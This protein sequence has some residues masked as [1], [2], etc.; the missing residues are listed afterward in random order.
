MKKLLIY[1]L[2]IFI[3]L[4][5]CAAEEPEDPGVV[6]V[7]LDTGIS[8]QAIDPER[9]LL[10][11]NY[12]TD[13]GDTEDRIN[14]GTAVASVILGSGSAGV[15]GLAP[16]VYLVPLV[17]T[18]KKE[19]VQSVSPET[20]AQAIRDGVDV[21][22]GDVLNISLG[23]KEDNPE[24][25]KAIAYAEK[26]GV[27]VVSAVGNEGDC[28]DIYYPAG[29]E[30]VIAVGSHDKNLELSDFSQRNGTADIL[31]PGEDIWLASRNGKTYGA[32]GTSY[33]TAYVSAAVANLLLE[34]P[35]VSPAQVRQRL[36]DAATDIGE[37]DS[38]FGILN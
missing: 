14:H 7:L 18:D 23:I 5:G 4:S 20:L 25:R 17:I 22:S 28:P 31:A 26:Q 38:G 6:V 35:T 16:N 19:G 15:E 32:K 11:W 10:G 30:T 13:S 29:Y 21:Y 2:T 9:I 12:V 34:D 37:P 24:I 1:L 8:T 27:V 36:F 3:L 33:A